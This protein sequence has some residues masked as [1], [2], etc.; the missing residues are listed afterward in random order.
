MFPCLADCSRV[1]GGLSTRCS[2]TRC[3]SCFS[4]VLKHS[5]F[6]PFVQLFVDERSLADR[7][8]RGRG[9][10]ARHKLLL[11]C[12]RVGCGP[13]VFRGALLVVL[14]RLT[15]YPLEGRGLSARCPQ[16]VRPS[17]ADRPP[18]TAQGC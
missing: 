14:L 11:D 18:G 16:T 1:A 12:P 3:S 15:D 17:L 7:P 10:S 2:L 9:L 8:P 4:L 13:S 6:D 5:V